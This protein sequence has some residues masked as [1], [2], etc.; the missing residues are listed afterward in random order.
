M[1][2]D[3]DGS[4]EVTRAA[5]AAENMRGLAGAGLSLSWEKHPSPSLTQL[6]CWDPNK[7]RG[8]W[9]VGG[10]DM[11]KIKYGGETLLL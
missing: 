7:L 3:F 9:P 11:W 1:H 4:G 10:I 6:T 5:Q 2:W 8:L